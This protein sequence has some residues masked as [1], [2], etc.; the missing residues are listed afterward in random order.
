MPS[1]IVQD[2]RSGSGSQVSVAGLQ[3]WQ[4]LLQLPELQ[5]VCMRRGEGKGA[6][7]AQK[8]SSPLSSIERAR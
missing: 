1:S 8:G 2:T 3:A 4:A 5:E 7:S 6:F